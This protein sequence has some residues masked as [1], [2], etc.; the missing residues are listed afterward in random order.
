[1]M[2]MLAAI[3]GRRELGGTGRTRV[4][5]DSDRDRCGSVRG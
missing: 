3:F 5:G 2:R 1:M 4:G